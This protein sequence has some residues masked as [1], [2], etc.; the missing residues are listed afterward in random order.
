M[1][2]LYTRVFLNEFHKVALIYWH[3]KFNLF[4]EVLQ[5]GLNFLGMSLM[6]H[7]GSMGFSEFGPTLLG[8]IMWVYASY[9]FNVGYNSITLESRSGTLE[10]LFMSPAPQPVIYLGAMCSTIVSSSIIIACMYGFFAVVCGISIPFNWM[11]VPFFLGTLLGLMGFGFI[12]GGAT[13]LSKNATG[14][15]DLI[16]YLL[17]YFNGSMIPIDKLPWPV[18]YLSDTLPTTLGIKIIREILFEGVSVAALWSRGV[19]EIFIINTL[20]Y[21]AAGVIIFLYAEKVARAR[22]YL[23]GY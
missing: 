5:L 16:T 23:G 20:I 21:C 15:T 8:Y 7:A 9:I 12:I 13:L 11:V 14:F 2:G 10:Q 4:M 19:V 22:G 3:Y 1:V 18:Q 6:L 17:L